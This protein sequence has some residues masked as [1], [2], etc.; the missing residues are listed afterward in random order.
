MK[1][2]AGKQIP[3]CAPQGGTVMLIDSAMYYNLLTHIRKVQG[4][5]YQVKGGQ[6]VLQDLNYTI[7]LI[8]QMQQLGFENML[9]QF[10]EQ[11]NLEIKPK[12]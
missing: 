9:R 2:Q 1:K 8:D 11:H 6:E 12:E 7:S 5:L 4:K 10:A 3:P